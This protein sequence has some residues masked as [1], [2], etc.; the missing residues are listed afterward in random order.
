MLPERPLIRMDF[1]I[2]L[3]RSAESYHVG[4]FLDGILWENGENQRGR[5]LLEREGSRSSWRMWDIC[6]G[7]YVAS[8]VALL[9]GY[10]ALKLTMKGPEGA[11]KIYLVIQDERIH[12][13]LKL[14]NRGGWPID[15]EACECDPRSN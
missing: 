12:T 8:C 13:G 6:G 1:F 15:E 11:R 9:E 3:F 7:K 4:S 5:R 10:R 14:E 2:C